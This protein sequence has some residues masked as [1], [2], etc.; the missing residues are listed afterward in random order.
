LSL[1]EEKNKW[2]ADV[3][4]TARAADVS[5]MRSVSPPRQAAGRFRR[6][7]MHAVRLVCSVSPTRI[8]IAPHC[9]DG[10]SDS[11]DVRGDPQSRET[12]AVLW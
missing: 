12:G 10:P 8:S 5:S 4:P 7:Q 1:D 9:S 11:A 6:S 2:F 3:T